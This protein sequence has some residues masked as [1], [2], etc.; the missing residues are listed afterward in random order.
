M[1]QRRPDPG[2][3]LI[4]AWAAYHVVRH[5]FGIS[6]PVLSGSLLLEG[7]RATLYHALQA[8]FALAVVV[9]LL[10]PTPLAYRLTLWWQAFCVTLALW[11]FAGF[12]FGREQA[13]PHHQA[14]L[15]PEADLGTLSGIYLVQTAWAFLVAALILLYLWRRRPL[16]YKK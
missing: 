7:A 9:A 13:M 5:L 2:L 8:V 4:A 14:V 6:D 1:T 12:L 10:R 3:L 11:N 16:F 15:G